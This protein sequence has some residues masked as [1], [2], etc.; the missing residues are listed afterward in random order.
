MSKLGPKQI[1]VSPSIRKTPLDTR[2]R[3]EQT[4]EH[5]PNDLNATPSNCREMNHGHTSMVMAC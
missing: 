2:E 5:A 1:A 3:L 4:H